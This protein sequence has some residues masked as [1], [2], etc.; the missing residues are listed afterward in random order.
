MGT[1][2]LTSALRRCDSGSRGGTGGQN[3]DGVPAR[4]SELFRECDAR[5]IPRTLIGC[6]R[7]SRGLEL[8]YETINRIK[9][10]A[11]L[12]SGRSE[13]VQVMVAGV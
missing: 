12:G 5:D 8:L 9:P 11:E 13:F 10:T 6:P 2:T 1:G 7:L 4:R 3:C